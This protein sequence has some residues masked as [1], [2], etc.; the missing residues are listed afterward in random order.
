MKK[1]CRRR[2]IVPLP[3]R[4]LRP[5]LDAGQVRDLSLVHHVNLDLLA[6]GQG[7]EFLMWQWAESILLWSRV[8]EML[9]AGEPEMKAQLE[10]AAGVIRR[11]GRTGRA[12]FTGPEYQLAKDG[13]AHMDAL[14]KLT[15]KPTA[16]MAADWAERKTHR[17]A[18]L[19]Q[20]GGMELARS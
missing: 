11:F 3:P 10:L 8:A 13:V 1:H 14:A 6:K 17:L 2:V 16:E 19:C 5:K 18:E 7:D 9:Q 15:D 20:A 4:G 12:V